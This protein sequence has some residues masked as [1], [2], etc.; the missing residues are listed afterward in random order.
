[1]HGVPALAITSERFMH[2]L[3]EIAHTPKDTPDPVDPSKLVAIASFLH[4][5]LPVLGTLNFS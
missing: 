3:A 2:I 5:L 1:M 4:D